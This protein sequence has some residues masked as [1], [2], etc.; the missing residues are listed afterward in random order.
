MKKIKLESTVKERTINIPGDLT[1]LFKETGSALG[2]LDGLEKLCAFYRENYREPRPGEL[3]HF[4]EKIKEQKEEK[5]KL[6]D[7]VNVKKKN[8]AEQWYEL[9]LKELNTLAIQNIQLKEK[10]EQ[11]QL[12]ILRSLTLSINQMIQDLMARDG[13]LYPLRLQDTHEEITV[14]ELDDIEDLV[15]P[16]KYHLQ[17][18]EKKIKKKLKEKDIDIPGPILVQNYQAAIEKARDHLHQRNS[19]LTRTGSLLAGLGMKQEFATLNT[20]QEETRNKVRHI[21]PYL[22]ILLLIGAVFGS[23]QLARISQLNKHLAK[24]SANMTDRVDSI[25]TAMKTMQTQLDTLEKGQQQTGKTLEKTNK[26]YKEQQL[27]LRKGLG[28]IQYQLH[29]ISHKQLLLDTLNARLP[30]NNG[31]EENDG[32]DALQ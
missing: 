16:V 5:E 9:P 15:H 17:V 24:Q 10:A 21:F 22:W 11:L 29:Q 8:E 1:L 32:Q 19:K 14:Q 28:N 7:P 25:K 4:I 18:D 20:F 13:D 23:I 31:M 26:E 30:V 2:Q 6:F 27:N 3:D 12:E